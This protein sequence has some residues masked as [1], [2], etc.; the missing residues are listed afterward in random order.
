M[1][2]SMKFRFYRHWRVP[3][4]FFFL[5]FLSLLSLPKASMGALMGEAESHVYWSDISFGGIGLSGISLYNQWEFVWTTTTAGGTDRTNRYGWTD[6][7]I[8][9]GSSTNYSNSAVNNNE[10][11]T[12]TT[13]EYGGLESGYSDGQSYRSTYFYALTSGFLTIDLNYYIYAFSDS[14]E[15]YSSSR[16]DS[17][18]HGRIY[19]TNTKVTYKD[20]S[21][22]SA[23]A[24]DGGSEVLY[25]I[26]SLHL[27]SYFEKGEVGIFSFDAY[28]IVG[29]DADT[30]PPV[31]EPTTILLLG[32]GLA[33]LAGA[34]RKMKKA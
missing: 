19:N 21:K 7:S 33:G 3:C 8:T 31:P 14:D 9:N 26:G 32:I 4:I 23:R 1:K 17:E 34:R 22:L 5:T 27:E 16:A 30:R 10:L 25:D 29:Y 12:H 20:N 18:V 28:S 15:L 11:V 2:E 13:A 24:K 6:L